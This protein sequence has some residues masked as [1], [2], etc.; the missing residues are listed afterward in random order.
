MPDILFF[1][2]LSK[3]QRSSCYNLKSKNV[4]DEVSMGTNL[5][6]F[7]DY[8]IRRI[9]DEGSEIWFF[10]VVDIVQALTQQPD[11]LTARKYWNK[12]KSRLKHEGSQVVTN[13][14]QLK[15]PAEDG[16]MRL[17]DAASAETLLKV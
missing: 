13:C 4:C 2:I 16:R 11:Y 17:T 7:E 10:S 15:M 14:H 3:N 8:K 1:A 6:V 9:Y 12:L 5:T